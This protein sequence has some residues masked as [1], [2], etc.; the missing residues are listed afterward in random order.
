MEGFIDFDPKTIQSVGSVPG[1]ISYTLP[2]CVFSKAKAC[3]THHVGADAVKRL[4][5]IMRDMESFLSRYPEVVV[6]GDFISIAIHHCFHGS[7]AVHS[8]IGSSDLEL[9]IIGDEKTCYETLYSLIERVNVRSS[10]VRDEDGAVFWVY[11]NN[12]FRSGD[13]PFN[14]LYTSK[15]ESMIRIRVKPLMIPSMKN[16][17]D[18]F[19]NK[20]ID[21]AKFALAGAGK[22]LFCTKDSY[23]ALLYGLCEL[24]ITRTF[25][26]SDILAKYYVSGYDFKIKN[27]PLCTNVTYP[28]I[29]RDVR[30]II[31]LKLCYIREIESDLS[32]GNTKNELLQQFKLVG[33][34]PKATLRIVGAGAVRESLIS[35]FEK[36]IQNEQV[37]N[38]WRHVATYNINKHAAY[39]TRAVAAETDCFML[40]C[41]NG[42]ESYVQRLLQVDMGAFFTRSIHLELVEQSNWYAFRMYKGV[43]LATF[44]CNQ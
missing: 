41:F 4:E 20:Y 15:D 27:E 24:D 13:V 17:G 36:G 39:M 42:V 38:D 40:V 2:D 7:P 26:H 22:K 9:Y 30:N 37:L 5:S 18:I 21:C 43:D 28:I 29:D 11:I 8:L 31:F 35:L 33:A 19:R 12:I 1:I 34:S 23:N 10:I 14:L 16:L 6:A 32:R 44:L 3:G 25:I